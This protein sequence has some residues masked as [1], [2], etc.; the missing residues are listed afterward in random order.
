M[1][2]TIGLFND[3]KA[4]INCGFF[5]ENPFSFSLGK[6]LT[7]GEQKSPIN[8]RARIPFLSAK[9]SMPIVSRRHR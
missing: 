8:S 4:F 5:I 3:G 6:G 1:F 7:Y 9:L 2:K